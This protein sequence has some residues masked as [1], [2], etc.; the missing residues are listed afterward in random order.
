MYADKLIATVNEFRPTL[1]IRS[2]Y[3]HR[4]AFVGVAFGM[5][6]TQS[7]SYWVG[8]YDGHNIVLLTE[9]SKAAG[10]LVMIFVGAYLT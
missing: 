2:H 8:V 5:C 10:C 4:V 3:G 6:L 1:N 9:D 7:L